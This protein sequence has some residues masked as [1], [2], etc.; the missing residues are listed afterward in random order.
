MVTGCIF[1][2]HNGHVAL[3]IYCV[4]TSNWKEVFKSVVNYYIEQ[5]RTALVLSFLGIENNCSSSYKGKKNKWHE[6][7]K[8]KKNLHSLLWFTST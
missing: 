4:F 6:I 2:A 5:S 1:V 3:G 7:L 8:Q